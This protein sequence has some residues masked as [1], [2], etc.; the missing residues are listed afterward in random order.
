MLKPQEVKHALYFRNDGV[1]YTFCVLYSV[2]F[3]VNCTTFS[4]ERYFEIKDNAAF[5]AYGDKID[6]SL[7]AC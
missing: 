6:T 4:S 3:N 5:D 1:L 2:V 7:S